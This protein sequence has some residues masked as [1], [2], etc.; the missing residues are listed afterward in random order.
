[1]RELQMESDALF[2]FLDNQRTLILAT[3]RGDGAPVA[4]PMW[5]CRVGEV[6]YCNTA[7]ESA[8]VRHLSEDDRVAVVVESGEDYFSLRGVRMEGHCRVVVDPSEIARVEA[9]RSAKARRIGS[10][11]QG[12][13]DSFLKSRDR[14]RAEGRRVWLRIDTD[15]TR[16]WDFG[17]LREHYRVVQ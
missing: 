5:F 3:L 8:K 13:P 4:V 14:L 17:S 11:L 1:M 2:E 7:V 6:L 16:T 9:A 12:L 10:G 15:R